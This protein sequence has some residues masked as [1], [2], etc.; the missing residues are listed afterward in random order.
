MWEGDIAEYK[1]CE[2]CADLYAALPC[3]MHGDLHEQYANYLDD[4]GVNEAWS[5]SGKVLNNHK[6]RKI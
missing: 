5:K 4:I 3:V 2:P 1:T 6:E